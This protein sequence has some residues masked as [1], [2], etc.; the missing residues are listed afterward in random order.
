VNGEKYH[1]ISHDAFTA[2]IERGEFLERA[3]VH[4]DYMYGTKYEDIV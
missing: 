2:A 3:T 4:K 1:H